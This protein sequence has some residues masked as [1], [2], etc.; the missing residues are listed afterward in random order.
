MDTEEQKFLKQHQIQQKVYGNE[1]FWI[2]VVRNGRMIICGCKSSDEDARAWIYDKF[3]NDDSAKVWK[4]R[5][6]DINA[7][8]RCIRGTR[9]NSGEKLD[10]VMQRFKRKL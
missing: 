8:S 7:A 10:T 5:S 2:T 3:P 6:R 1:Y 9:L 4:I